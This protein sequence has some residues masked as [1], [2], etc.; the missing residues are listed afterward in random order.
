MI[1]NK[2]ILGSEDLTLPREIR[3]EVFIEEQ[4][5]PA[6]LEMDDEDRTAVH[7]VIFD[8]DR[9]VATGRLW[10][11][12]TSFRLG[13]CAVLREY[14]G[15]GIGD[16]LV[17]LL[18]VRAFQSGARE[19]TAHAQLHARA[20]YERFGF[21]AVGE[22]FEEAGIQHVTMVLPVSEAVF[23]SSCGDFQRPF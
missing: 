3:R 4:H 23:P 5:V 8:D 12:G 2:W 11:D 15:Q 7:A 10:F 16:L 20:F 6:E 17:R 1:T 22:P 18:L 13:R 14:R 21:R 19:L 9:C